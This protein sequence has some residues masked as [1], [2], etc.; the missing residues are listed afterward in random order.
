VIEIRTFEGD[1]RQAATFTTTI[2]TDAYGGHHQMPIW[3]ERYYDWQLF[4]RADNDRSLAVAA[5]DSGKLVGTLFAEQ[6][7]FR[8]ENR[9]VE[10]SMSSWLTVDPRT[11]GCS[12]GRRLVDELRNRH[13]QRGL[14]FSIGFCVPGTNGPAFWGS[15]PDTIFF[16]KIGYWARV[17]DHRAVTNWL[18]IGGQ[19]I[20]AKLLGPIMAPLGEQSDAP[21]VR[22]YVTGDLDRCLTLTCSLT[23]LSQVGHRWTKQRLNHQLQ[24]RDI[25]QTLVFERCGVVEGFINYYSMD[26]LLRGDIRVALVDLLA[27]GGLKR[28][29][30]SA[31]IETALHRMK[32]QNMQLAMVP[33]MVGCPSG[34]LA[35]NRFIPLPAEYAVTCAIP[36]SSIP[37]QK[38]DEYHLI[39][40]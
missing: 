39:V 4:G 8:L 24:Y 13:R 38:L 21:G 28:R 33:R 29:D 31:L 10:G 34:A 19:W 1:S 25:P 16:G 2:W 26:F 32:A 20:A 40:R 12:V 36:D 37:R 7:P 9:D 5:Y 14:A 30:Q 11:K 15:M 22:P 23:N 3:D 35:R 27:C 18:N 17:L 6:F